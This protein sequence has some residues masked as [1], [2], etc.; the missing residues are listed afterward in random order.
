MHWIAVGTGG[1]LG[2]MLRFALSGLIIRRFPMG[3]FIANSIG[4]L[5]IGFLVAL[6][7]K[8]GWPNAMMR[9]F[10]ITGFLGGLTTFSTLAYQTWEL[11]YSGSLSWAAFNLCSNLIIG[12]LAVWLGVCLGEW[13]GG[14]RA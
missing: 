4:C 6:S 12:L 11:N 14:I 2:A 3:T 5:L 1:A 9:S 8:T 13:L 10:L 7:L